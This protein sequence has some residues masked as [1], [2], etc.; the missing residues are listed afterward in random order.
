MKVK[1]MIVIELPYITKMV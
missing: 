1:L